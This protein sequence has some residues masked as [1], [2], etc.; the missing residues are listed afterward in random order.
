[1]KFTVYHW[2]LDEPFLDPQIFCIVR[3]PEISP[4]PLAGK[5]GIKR[6]GSDEKREACKR[7]AMVTVS[8][9]TSPGFR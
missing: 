8:R 4:S 6:H 7:L 9:Y 1:M 3:D 5:Q 2:T